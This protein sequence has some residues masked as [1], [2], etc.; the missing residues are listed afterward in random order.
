[1]IP[2]WWLI[3]TCNS[4]SRDLMPTFGL[5][6]HQTHKRCPDIQVGKTSTHIERGKTK[7]K[8]KKP[9]SWEPRT[10]V[11]SYGTKASP[12]QLQRPCTQV[13]WGGGAGGRGRRREAAAVAMATARACVPG[14][15][16]VEVRWLL[17]H[18]GR[19]LGLLGRVSEPRGV[20]GP[21]LLGSSE[22]SLLRDKALF[23]PD[24]FS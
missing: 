24:F 13:T 4:S 16:E 18:R 5:H 8:T 21:T 7:H 15:L 1:M 20:A 2:T 14:M 19:K 9:C 11:S 10:I 6:K 17:T 3:V 23:R 22:A 12:D